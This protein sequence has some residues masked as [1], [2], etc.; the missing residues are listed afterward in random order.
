MTAA[1][2]DTGPLFNYLMLR[3]WRYDAALTREQVWAGTGCSVAWLR[4]LEAGRA[5]PSLDMLGRLA[6]FYGH[7]PGELL[8]G[9]G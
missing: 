5:I 7:E 8:A 2:P 1:V 6:R 9:A 4:D 3:Q